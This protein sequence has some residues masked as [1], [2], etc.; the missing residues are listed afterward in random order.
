M[1]PIHNATK[2]QREGIKPGMAPFISFVFRRSSVHIPDNFQF[3]MA[4]DIGHPSA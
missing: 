3:S 2:A 4:L 1:I